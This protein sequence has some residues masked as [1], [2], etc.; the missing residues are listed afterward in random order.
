MIDGEN[1]VGQSQG[2]RNV[3]IP[4]D[5]TSASDRV[6]GRVALL[7]LAPNARLIL[8]H[9]VPSDLE[10]EARTHAD[11]EA[12][13]SLAREA[14]HLARSLR[15][16]VTITQVIM[17]GAPASAIADCSAEYHVEM[18]VMG[19]GGG[20][21]L[22][23]AFVGS[24]AERVMRRTKLPVLMVRLA[25]HAAYERPALAL[26]SDDAA[27][28]ALAQLMKIAPVARASVT[29]IHAY[30]V[31]YQRIIEPA[32]SDDDDGVVSGPLQVEATHR[33]A[34]LLSAAMAGAKMAP[35][36]A[37]VWR[38]HVRVGVPRFVIGKAVESTETDLLVM[39]TRGRSGI[40]YAFLGT[41][42][43]DVMRAVSC[44]VLVVPPPVNEG[45]VAG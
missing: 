32:L 31:S 12:K 36:D 37:P 34:A 22:R 2:Y 29:V 8:L 35:E 6:L 1:G 9:V 18:I 15:T 40:A 41:V 25:P 11:L 26:N 14:T 27:G 17:H 38:Q 28:V 7:P 24:T 30:D 3:L 45:A 10:A 13:R 33:L 39:G 20:H 44:D 42:A 21:A 19:R 43:G 23:D 4:I 5:L 16:D